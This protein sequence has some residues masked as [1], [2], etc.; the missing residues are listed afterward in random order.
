MYNNIKFKFIKKRK[1]MD[2]KTFESLSCKVQIHL[3]QDCQN[4]LIMTNPQIQIRP[5]TQTR[6]HIQTR[7]HS[8]TVR[9]IM[10]KD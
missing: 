4:Q 9:L 1:I 10:I 8:V 6:L 2:I 7:L 3:A 5:L